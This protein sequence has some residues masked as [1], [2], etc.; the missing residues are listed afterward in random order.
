[1]L[2]LC[3]ACRLLESSVG[4]LAHVHFAANVFSLPLKSDEHPRGV[5]SEH[6]L[7]LVLAAMFVFIFFDVDPVK[8]FPLTFV[9]R[10]TTQQL[11]KLVDANVR[12]VNATGWV[13]G[14]TDKFQQHFGSLAD[15]G[16][17][18]VR[19]LLESGMSIKEVTWSQIVPTAGAMVAN[20]AQ[21]VSMR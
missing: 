19:R 9:A 10:S 18:M 16:V 14:I 3:A 5:F 1:M 7:Y 13:S 6:E 2:P 17:H 21:V 15:Y 12:F 20:Q 8:T 4:N 11:G